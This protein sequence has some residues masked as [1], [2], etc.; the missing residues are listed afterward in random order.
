MYRKMAKAGVMLLDIQS[1]AVK[2]HEL[3]LDDDDTAFRAQLM[4]WMS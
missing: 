4:P 3:A 1:D 2:Q